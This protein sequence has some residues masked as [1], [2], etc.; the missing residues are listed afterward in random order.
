MNN[1]AISYGPDTWNHPVRMLYLVT[2]EVNDPGALGAAREYS[3]HV[4]NFH[5]AEA[6][7][8]AFRGVST[9]TVT[10]EPD[11]LEYLKRFR[12]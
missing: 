6:I 1:L 12:R 8:T 5:N 9:V 2:I 3:F 10:F 7:K 4:A 11:V